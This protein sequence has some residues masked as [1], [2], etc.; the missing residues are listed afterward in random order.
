MIYYQICDVRVKINII[1]FA[2][3]YCLTEDSYNKPYTNTQE[4][5]RQKQYLEK[6]NNVIVAETF[7]TRNL[8]IGT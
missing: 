2:G 4:V 1:L 8:K 3:C 6:D 5:V 7:S